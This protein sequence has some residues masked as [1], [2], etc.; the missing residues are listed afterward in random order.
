MKDTDEGPID[1]MKNAFINKHKKVIIN[2]R[3]A[4]EINKSTTALDY[5]IIS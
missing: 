5:D 3:A 1:F 4:E 2:N